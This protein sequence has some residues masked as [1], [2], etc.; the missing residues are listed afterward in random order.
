[1][2]AP[3]GVEPLDPAPP[4]LDPGGIPRIPGTIGICGEE[5]V[6]R[7]QGLPFPRRRAR[8][9]PGALHDRDLD[10]RAASGRP[11]SGPGRVRRL[12]RRI[13][14][15]GRRPG[16]RHVPVED[17]LAEHPFSRT[18]AGRVAITARSRSAVR[19]TF[20]TNV[21]DATRTLRPLGHHEA[22]HRRVDGAVEGACDAGEGVSSARGKGPRAAA[23][24]LSTS[25]SSTAPLSSTVRRSRSTDSARARRPAKVTAYRR[26]AST[27]MIEVDPR[28]A[29]DPAGRAGGDVSLE[30]SLA[31][32][33]LLRAR[34]HGRA[35]P[36]PGIGRRG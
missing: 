1:M 3:A 33:P 17:V 30:E 20:P 29:G 26:P 8:P 28:R 10:V 36:S 19:A 7:E 35:P 18:P 32:Q 6:G 22:D 27:S 24:L 2:I 14:G 21:T 34:A 31:P 11:R 5:L 25:N 9:S 12:R 4:F 15:P 13:P 16:R 23:R